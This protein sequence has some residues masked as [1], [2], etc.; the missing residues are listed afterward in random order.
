MGSNMSLRALY[1]EQFILNEFNM[2][3][4]LL[5]LYTNTK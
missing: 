5:D 1:V 2:N 4:P 3:K